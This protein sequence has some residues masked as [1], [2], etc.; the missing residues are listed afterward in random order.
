MAIK[1]AAII[2]LYENKNYGN[3]LQNYALQEILKKE[4]LEVATITNLQ[5]EY[6]KTPSEVFYSL[7]L[8]KTCKFV[9]KKII[10]TFALESIAKKLLAILGIKKEKLKPQKIEER[11]IAKI[12][13]FDK[14]IKKHH[15]TP[16]NENLSKIDKAYDLFVIGSDQIWNPNFLTNYKFDLGFFTLKNKKISYAASIAVPVLTG[17]TAKTYIQAFN[18]FAEGMISVREFE[19]AKLIKDLTGKEVAT[20]LDP[21]MLLDTS[22]WE[23]VLEEPE[24][25]PK[26][27]YLLTY[28]LGDVSLERR[29][30]IERVAEKYNLEIVNLLDE[31]QPEFYNTGVGEFLWFFKNAEVIFAD[32]FHAGVFSILYEKPFYILNRAGMKQKH[33]MNSRFDTLLSAFELQDRFLKEY[34]IEKVNFDVDY[35]KAGQ[36][37]ERR[38]EESLNF[39]RNAL[40]KCGKPDK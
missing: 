6:K 1:K 12:K 2:T 3:K 4:G 13:L 5:S 38:R 20:V 8:M 24:V 31:T 30:F 27:K 35:T 16:L 32:S 28:I 33:N 19:G 15:I 21:T 23:K 22:E 9:F 18:A 39:L 14:L 34:D 10:I 11:R 37:L 25:K 29:N 17:K 36:I 26:K 7:G 40:N